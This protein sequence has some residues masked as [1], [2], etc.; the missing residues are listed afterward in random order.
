MPE[1][2]IVASINPTEDDDRISQ[3]VLNLF[4]EAKITIE[5]NM[6]NAS[7]M[8]MDDFIQRMKQQNIRD[9]ARKI[10]F[11]SVKDD[12]IKFHLSKQAAFVDKVN[13]TEG[14]SVLGDL[15]VTIKTENIEPNVLIQQMTG[16]L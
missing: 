14:N 6:L 2:S 7:T 4:P 16:V 9:S 10:L 8:N 13:F 3:A 11:N 12:S 5:G 1:I 15:I